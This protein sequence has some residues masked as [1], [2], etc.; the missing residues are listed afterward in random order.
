VKIYVISDTHV[1]CKRYNLPEI[2]NDINYVF[3]QHINNAIEHK[4]DLVLHCGELFD[5]SYVHPSYISFVVEQINKLKLNNIHLVLIYGN[6]DISGFRYERSPIKILEYFDN[7][8]VLKNNSYQFKDVNFIGLSYT[9]LKYSD[10]KSFEDLFE[11]IVLNHIDVNTLNIGMFHQETYDVPYKTSKNDTINPELLKDL[12]Y[13]FIGHIHN[14][15][16]FDNYMFVGSTYALGFDQ[17]NDKYGYLFDIESDVRLVQK[18][19]S[20][21]EFKLCYLQYTEDDYELI[22]NDLNKLDINSIVKVKVTI[23]NTSIQ[24]MVRKYIREIQKKYD[25]RLHK[26]FMTYDIQ[27]NMNKL[28]NKSMNSYMVSMLDF[29]ENEAQKRFVSFYNSLELKNNISHNKALDVVTESV[30]NYIKQE[31]LNE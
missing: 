8:V 12:T 6:H 18:I 20:K 15:S 26:L 14:S 5:M 11:V 13:S 1:G 9:N 16:E 30:Q 31:V 4:V 17:I 23:S 21:P 7:V 10:F 28:S 24:D 27:N 22:E 25:S 19:E 2:T 29:C 3:E